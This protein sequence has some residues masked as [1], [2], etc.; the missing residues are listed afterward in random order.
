MKPIAMMACAAALTVSSAWISAPAQAS[1]TESHRQENLEPK[2]D[3]EYEKGKAIFLGRNQDAKALKYC[4]FHKGKLLKVKRSTVKQF[5]RKSLAEF[6]AGILDCTNPTQSA[7][8][9]LDDEHRNL[10]TH[11]L[12][13]RYFLR[14]KGLPTLN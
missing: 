1:G 7:L 9:Q 2:I 4:A 8:S 12:N 6:E 10:V 14:L 11:Y 3:P 5:R 13:Q